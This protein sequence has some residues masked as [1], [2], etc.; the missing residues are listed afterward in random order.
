MKVPIHVNKASFKR[1]VIDSAQPVLVDF[2]AERS[3]PCQ[4]MAPVIEEIAREHQGGLKLVKVNVDQNP[5][6][7][8]QYHIETLPTLVY[9]INGL[10][11]DHIVGVTE[12]GEIVQRLKAAR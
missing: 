5:K 12:K 1:E 4:A 8:E 11:H 10:V 7:A 9:F 3:V 6:L 2:W